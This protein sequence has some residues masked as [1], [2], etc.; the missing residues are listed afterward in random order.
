MDCNFSRYLWIYIYY[1]RNYCLFCKTDAWD[2][3]KGSNWSPYFW[4][5]CEQKIKGK[6]GHRALSICLEYWT[7]HSDSANTFWGSKIWNRANI[8][9]PIEKCRQNTL[10]ITLFIVKWLY[11]KLY[12]TSIDFVYKILIFC[13]TNSSEKRTTAGERPRD[14]CVQFLANNYRTKNKM[15]TDLHEC[16]FLSPCSF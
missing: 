4:G 1:Y 2:S 10:C 11:F 15:H 7:V 9:I 13:F 3:H 8:D 12:F 16:V 6:Q 5:L 14:V